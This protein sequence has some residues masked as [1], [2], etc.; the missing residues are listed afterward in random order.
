M[1]RGA[2]AL[3]LSAAIALACASS[4]A[5]QDSVSL[6]GLSATRAGDSAVIELHTSGPADFYVERFT[7]GNWISV[8]SNSLALGAGVDEIP[9][10]FDRPEIADLATGASLAVE[11]H[12]GS[13]R[14]YLGAQADRSGVRLADLGDVTRVTI[15]M[16]P[17]ESALAG[18]E[19]AALQETA[20]PEPA[21][22]ADAEPLATADITPADSAP[23]TAALDAVETGDEAASAEAAAGSFYLPRQHETTAEDAAD[24]LPE[25]IQTPAATEPEPLPESAEVNYQRLLDDQG[26]S[27]SGG[28]D[29]GAG[30]MDQQ[31]MEEI[32]REAMQM[33][34]E[35]L[36]D[37]AAPPSAAAEQPAAGGVTTPAVS[38]YDPYKPQ[39]QV[40]FTEG[41]STQLASGKD[42]L[43]NIRIELFEILGTPLDQALTLMVAPT[44]YNIIVDSS[45]GSNIVSLSFKDS[46]TD[47]KSALDLLTKAYGLE[48][49]VE[50][51]TIVVA[52]RSTINGGLVEFEKRL[53]V[54]NYA[55]PANVKNILV[56][57]KLLNEDQV[58]VYSGEQ[59]YGDVNDSTKLSATTGGSADT[60]PIETN[61]S[62]T[63]RNA[64]LVKAVPQQMEEIARVIGDLDRKPTIVDLEVRVCE[65][66]ER[67][68]KDL[69]ITVN[70][71]FLGNTATSMQW[72]ENANEDGRF[73][74]FSLG[75]MLRSPLEFSVTLNHLV[76]NG[77]ARV[78]AQPQ[79]TTVEGKQAIYFAGESIP[80]ISERKIDPRTGQETLTVE[81]VDVG[82]TLNFKPRLDAD[83]K[84]TIDVNPIVSSLIEMME[85]SDGVTAPR[86]QN[87]QLHTTVRVSDCEPFVMAGMISERDTET[88]SKIPGLADLPLVGK[89]FRSRSH[90]KD[91]TEII[92][93]VVPHIRK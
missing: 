25:F 12:H 40:S 29:S 7:M 42:A 75:S 91:R 73:E 6:V 17:A 50:A 49:V 18:A 19:V 71:D 72:T 76:D 27:G 60:I 26:M 70:R 54:L 68:Q 79:L 31:S 5:A 57:T 3:L 87:R 35:M 77:D 21:G 4:I 11:R 28:T 83:G 38:F 2:R 59:A 64:V 85:I 89:L 44:D 51:G 46:Q 36:Q 48:Y 1:N 23:A 55:D 30:G 78:L 69:G 15:P 22:E 41:A 52:A 13:V 32:M 93:I 24:E 10:D 81:F 67:A 37:A 66:N 65:A 56:N 62:S 47:L 33:A 82:V 43:S 92:I 80:Y 53:F 86:T 34:G 20:P 61:L 39:A 45:V 90:D 74:A 16:L 14:I 84:L 63:P 9:L 88:I 58:E 8:W